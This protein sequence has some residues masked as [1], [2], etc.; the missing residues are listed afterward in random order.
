MTAAEPDA[1]DECDRCGHD[2]DEHPGNGTC[3]AYGTGIA[4]CPCWAFAEAA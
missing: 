3:T 4:K 1:W 2:R